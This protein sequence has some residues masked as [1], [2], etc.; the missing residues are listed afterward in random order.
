MDNEDKLNVFNIL[1]NVGF[2]SLK[3]H[4]GLKSARTQDALHSLPQEK[5]KIKI[6]IY[7]HMEMYLMI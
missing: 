6:L 5:A 1:E 4:K 7:Q 3:H 2:Y